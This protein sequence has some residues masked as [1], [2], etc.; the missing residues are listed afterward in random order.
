VKKIFSLLTAAAL[1]T[2]CATAVFAQEESGPEL[3]IS[4]E[5]KSGIY[6]EATQTEGELQ[7]RKEVVGLHSKDDAGSY[8]SMGRFRI[9]MDYDRGDGFGMKMRFTFQEFRN[10]LGGSWWSYGFGFGNFF[11]RQFIVSVGRLGGSPWG[12][13]GPEMWKELEEQAIGMRV[14]WKPNFLP[15]LNFGFVLNDMNSAKD[16][17]WPTDENGNAKPLTLLEIL[18]E[19]VIGISYTHDLFHVRAAYRLDG[20]YDLRENGSGGKGKEGDEI[21]Y[22][23][24]ERV[25][26]NYLPGFQLWALGYLVGIGAASNEFYNFQNWF[27]VQYDPPTLGPLE[28]PFT[29]QFR[30]GY[31]TIYNRSIL[32]LRPNFYW[33]F[34]NKFIS[35]GASFLWGQD[36][37]EGKLVGDHPY[38]Y[39]EVEPKI[40]LN[41]QSSYI[42]FVYNWRQDYYH[43]D[44]APFKPD[45]VTRYDP[46]NRT[47]FMNLRFCIY[48]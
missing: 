4:G 18:K 25:L 47:Q 12:T 30:I 16:Q 46:I 29:V 11:D 24:E 33:H 38:V 1:I 35:V 15:G 36:F 21:V 26:K 39:M 32:H 23:V 2:V 22:R 14:E 19:S 6:W 40:Q 48:F 8:P 31:D 44:K 34:F 9:N 10:D 27:F 37:G 3:K 13:G 20:D 42:A 17:G 7:G 41:F 43:A 5:A 28:T 45:G